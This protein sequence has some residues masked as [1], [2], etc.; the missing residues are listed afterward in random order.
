MKMRARVCGSMQK[1]V[2]VHQFLATWD[3]GYGNTK[4]ILLKY[5]IHSVI[6]SEIYMKSFIAKQVKAKV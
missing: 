3:I 4:K 1:E 5:D 6:T 2:H